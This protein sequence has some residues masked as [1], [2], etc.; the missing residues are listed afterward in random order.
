VGDLQEGPSW[1]GQAGLLD[2]EGGAAMSSRYIASLYFVASTFVG[3]GIGDITPVSDSERVFVV[4]AM[5]AGLL[6]GAVVISSFTS[7]TTDA[8]RASGGLQ[9]EKEELESF[10]SRARLP[11]ALRQR[12]TK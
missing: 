6:W 10:L 1:L 3:L 8:D 2:G 7:V 5:L 11:R 4:V 12:V 9:A